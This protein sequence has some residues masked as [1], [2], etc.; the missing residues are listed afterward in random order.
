[1]GL[2]LLDEIFEE[3][4]GKRE[5]IHMV[6]FV[7]HVKIQLLSFLRNP[8]VRRIIFSHNSELACEFNLLGTPTGVELMF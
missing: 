1:M 6:I 7:W 2:T 5:N 4:R 3:I 8:T